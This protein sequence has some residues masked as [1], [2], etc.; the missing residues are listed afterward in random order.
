M[1]RRYDVK[2]I[3]LKLLS[4]S[5]EGISQLKSK[6]YEKFDEDPPKILSMM[7]IYHSIEKKSYSL[8]ESIRKDISEILGEDIEDLIEVLWDA[9][10]GINTGLIWEMTRNNLPMLTTYL[11]KKIDEQNQS[12]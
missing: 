2:K 10:T 12:S 5:E 1:K 9:D 7:E 3:Y 4:L 8:P 6:K 11:Q